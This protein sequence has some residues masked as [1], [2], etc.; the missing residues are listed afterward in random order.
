MVFGV[1][2]WGSG[3]PRRGGSGVA[4]NIFGLPLGQVTRH[5]LKFCSSSLPGREGGGG[6]PLG[7]GPDPGGVG[8]F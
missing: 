5:F 4:D 2:P 3:W 1:A 8:H 6:G 7:V